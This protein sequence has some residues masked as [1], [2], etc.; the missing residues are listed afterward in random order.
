MPHSKPSTRTV[1]IQVADLGSDPPEEVFPISVLDA[2]MRKIS[3][4]ITLTYSLDEGADTDT[5][6]SNTCIGLQ[7][8]MKE[9]RF[10]AGCV[11]EDS[12]GNSYSKRT[13]DQTH[14]TVHIKDLRRTSYPSYSELSA[15]HFPVSELENADLLPPTFTPFPELPADGS[16]IPCTLVQLNLIRGGLIIGLCVNH[17]FVDARGMDNILARWAAHTRPLFDAACAAPPP[18]DPAWLDRT[19]L[20]VPADAP[21]VDYRI[22]AVPSMRCMP[23]GVPLG[24]GV[25]PDQMQSQIW[26]VPASKLKALKALASSPDVDDDDDG[27]DWVSTN[28]CLTALMWRCITRSR[29]ALHGIAPDTVPTDARPVAL[30]NAIDATA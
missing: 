6:I 23:D 25:T 2:V 29:L 5:I 9:Y 14:F 1:Q 15:R 11:H 27:G 28:D 8:L 16:G 21:A 10:L 4:P 13:R 24:A 3:N 17:R 26:H 19:P 18:L 20:T 12:K 7:K 30:M 22:P